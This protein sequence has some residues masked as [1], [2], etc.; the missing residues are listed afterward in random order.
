MK[1]I[2]RSV[3]FGTALGAVGL[4]ACDAVPPPSGSAGPPARSE[5]IPP[6]ETLV[7]LVRKA[8]AEIARD[9]DA[10]SRAR[11]LGALL[12]TLGPDAVP[13]VQQTL[14]DPALDLRG[15]EIELLARFWATHQPEQASLWA[16]QKSPRSYREAAVFAAL[17]VWAEADPQAAAK[18]A[19]SWGDEQRILESIVPIALVRGWYARNDPPELRQFLRDLD[20]G[21]PGQRALAAYIRVLIQTRGSEAAIRWAESLPE[22]DETDKTYKKTVYRRTVDALSL[23]DTEAAMRWCETQCD[24]PYGSDMRGLIGRNWALRDGAAALAWL[25]TAPEGHDRTLALKL[26]FD[27]WARTDLEAARAWMAAQTT[28][29][30]APW[31]R[32]IYPTYA[33]LLSGKDPAEA[34]RWA[35]RIENEQER[36]HLMIGVARVWRHLDEAAAEEWLLQSP[37]SEE[38]REKVRAPLEKKSP[39]LKG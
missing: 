37:L 39:K 8:L 5:T 12:P 9:E 24:G 30:P 3:F 26:T 7:D 4:T 36:E 6:G 21:V 27:L 23:L 22:D 17:S 19:W 33:Q 35:S 18:V 2:L 13:A 29:E 1:K 15:T 28:G 14:S 16:K 32:V 38:A 20:V 10:Y 31:V 25:S 34:M 11:R